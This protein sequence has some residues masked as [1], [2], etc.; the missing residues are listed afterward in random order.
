MIIVVGTLIRVSNSHRT[1]SWLISRCSNH[2][3]TKTLSTKVSTD[4]P[5]RWD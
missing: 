1:S 5:Y 2:G 4:E 3:S